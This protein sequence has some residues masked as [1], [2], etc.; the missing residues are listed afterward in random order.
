[1]FYD[2]VK[3]KAELDCTAKEQNKLDDLYPTLS[4]EMKD[5]YN[6]TKEGNS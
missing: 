2:R 1:M 4:Q 5:I 6:N 3:K